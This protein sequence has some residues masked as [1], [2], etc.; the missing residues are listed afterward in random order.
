MYA[1]ASITKLYSNLTT[2]FGDKVEDDT[3]N[4]LY[5]NHRFTQNNTNDRAKKQDRSIKIFY[6]FSFSKQLPFLQHFSRINYT[7]IEQL[8]WGQEALSQFTVV[9]FEP[10]NIA[11]PKFRLWL[12]SLCS[13]LYY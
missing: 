2:S 12:Q 8:Y 10:P 7:V 13:N 1:N 6:A 9:D 11:L 4:S 5:N 3:L